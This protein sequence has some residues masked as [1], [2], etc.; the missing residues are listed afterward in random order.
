MLLVGWVSAGEIAIF[1]SS[2]VLGENEWKEGGG[3]GGRGFVK[4]SEGLKGKKGNSRER[5]KERKL[6]SGE[7]K[8]GSRFALGLSL[9]RD[10]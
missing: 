4:A 5:A 1:D 6:K 8:A 2:R 9:P 7:R 3:G 10:K